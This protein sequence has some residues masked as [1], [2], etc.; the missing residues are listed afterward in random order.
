MGEE[1]HHSSSPRGH[2]VLA[3]NC[4]PVVFIHSLWLHASSWG[5]WEELFRA[6]GYEPIAPG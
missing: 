3:G 2:A 6:A 5:S 4:T 1:E